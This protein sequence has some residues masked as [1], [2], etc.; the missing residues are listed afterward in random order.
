MVGTSNFF[1]GKK[2]TSYGRGVEFGGIRIYTYMTLNP[3]Q[4]L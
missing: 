3:H 4:H 2:A 1:F